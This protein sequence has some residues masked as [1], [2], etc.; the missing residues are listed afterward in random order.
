LKAK[1][2]NDSTSPDDENSDDTLVDIKIESFLSTKGDNINATVSPLTIW[3]SDG[4]TCNH[5]LQSL[6]YQIHYDSNRVIQEVKAI[7]VGTNVGNTSII[8]KQD[9]EIEFMLTDS[10]NSPSL[11]PNDKV[12]KD[13]GNVGYQF[14]S[15]T[16]AGTLQGE[17]V[18]S[19][20]TGLKIMNAG[21]C[22]QNNS[23]VSLFIDIFL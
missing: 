12:D 4:N 16:V 14:A 19:S 18:K 22:I 6:K 1:G 23:M 9:F 20:T 11:I 8:M 17:K 21:S 5:A 13:V 2:S 10:E 3:D 15:P 7:I